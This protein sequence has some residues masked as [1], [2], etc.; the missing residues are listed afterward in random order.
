MSSVAAGSFIRE[1]TLFLQRGRV[2]DDFQKP[3]TPFPRTFE[4]GNNPSAA[5]NRDGP[6]ELANGFR[7]KRFVLVGVGLPGDLSLFTIA[8]PL[9]ANRRPG[10]HRQPGRMKPKPPRNNSEKA[11]M[12]EQRD[13]P[14]PPGHGH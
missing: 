10:D 4:M 14:Q 13:V 2:M 7:G 1:T 3:R 11:A 6:P 12:A 9:L 8:R 5:L